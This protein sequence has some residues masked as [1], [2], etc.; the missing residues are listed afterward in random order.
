MVE[1]SE[2]HDWTCGIAVPICPRFVPSRDMGRAASA[3]FGVTGS[4][5]Y[6]AG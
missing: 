3:R 5:G 4:A 6:Y 1:L 2:C